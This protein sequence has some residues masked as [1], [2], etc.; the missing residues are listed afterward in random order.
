MA[1]PIKVSTQIRGDA[2]Q[3]EDVDDVEFGE[4]TR[5]EK[6]DDVDGRFSFYSE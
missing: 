6:A 1:G 4:L 2:G 5:S 3:E